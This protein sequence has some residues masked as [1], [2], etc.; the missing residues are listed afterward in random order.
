MR[1]KTPIVA[2]PPGM[3]DWSDERDSLRAEVERLRMFLKI[4]EHQASSHPR[5]I[6]EVSRELLRDMLRPSPQP[7]LREGPREP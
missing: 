2:I 4:L 1:D 3:V 5:F 7:T 6:A